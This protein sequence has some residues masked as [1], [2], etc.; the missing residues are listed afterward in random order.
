MVH[1]FTHLESFRMYHISHSVLFILGLG[2]FCG[3]L[4]AWFFQKIKFPQVMG[5]II[6]GLIIGDFLMGG[7]WAI[8]GL[9]GNASYL[10]LPD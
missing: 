5:Y 8:I 4:G 3:L 1:R 10:V 9:W 2:I 6:I 7:I